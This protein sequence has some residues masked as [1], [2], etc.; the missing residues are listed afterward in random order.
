[1]NI[2]TNINETVPIPS[3]VL[4][5]HSFL[6]RSWIIEIS[7]CIIILT[8]SLSSIIIASYTTLAKPRNALDP[9][10]DK[11]TNPNY[12]PT[13]M[14]NCRFYIMNKL[15][16][17]IYDQISLSMVICMPFIGSGMLILLYFLLRNF[18]DLN[19]WLNWYILSISPMMIYFSLSSIFVL[20]VRKLSHSLFGKNSLKFMKRYRICVIED[21]DDYPLG[22]L[23]FLH[24]EIKPKDRNQFKKYV[25]SENLTILE[26]TSIELIPDTYNT[27]WIIDSKFLI[28]FP[29]SLLITGIFYYFPNN[30][31][32]LNFLSLNYIVSSISQLRLNRFKLAFLLL[33]GLFVYDIY[34]VFGTE[35]MES[36]ATQITIP[37]KL[38]IPRFDSTFSILG[39]G[40][41]IIPG[42]LIS[43]CLRFDLYNYH[44]SNPGLAFHHLNSFPKPYFIISNISYA[45]GLIITLIVLNVFK[46]GQPALLYL[47]PSLLVG[48]IGTSI[49]RKEFTQLW[50]F[51][52]D[53]S[54]FIPDK[55][56]KE[57]RD[58]NLNEDDDNE[59]EDD[60][61]DE[62]QVDENEIEQL[63]EMDDWI[64]RVELK[65]KEFGSDFDTDIDDFIHDNLYNEEDDDTFVIAGASTAEYPEEHDDDDGEDEDDSI[66]RILVNDLRSEP[67]EWYS[68]EE[69][70]DGV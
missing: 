26:P 49:K 63:D 38:L 15:D 10:I 52:E 65:R 2:T 36:V 40:D 51:T 57:P 32:I 27:N 56:E 64:D 8:L 1:M 60:E 6:N 35:I 28:L 42:T 11:D 23:E 7:T 41:I 67:K 22:Q 50:Q 12:D 18:E 70:E 29:I 45:I 46:A 17:L 39:L 19:Y 16:L 34:F 54:E 59:D 3:E 47:V 69:H 66:V 14:D 21:Q 20:T 37:I 33:L 61:D 43:L 48:I 62:F 9:R 55:K 44:K 4:E 53:I 58:F 13:D 31:F 24:D 30:P 5:L 25:Q 68:E